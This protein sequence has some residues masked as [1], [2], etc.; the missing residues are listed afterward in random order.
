[1][2]PAVL[3]LVAGALAA[4][5]PVQTGMKLGDFNRRRNMI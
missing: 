3:F 5:V 2:R 1:M 4:Q